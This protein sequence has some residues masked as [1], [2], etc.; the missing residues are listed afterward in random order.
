MIAQVQ[1]TTIP[2]NWLSG[3][4]TVATVNIGSACIRVGANA[5][6]N[7][8]ALTT[9]NCLATTAPVLG[10]SAFQTVNATLITV[11]TGALNYGS[12]WGG[13]NVTYGGL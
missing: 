9:I 1:D 11:P 7:C 13:L 8:Y 12:T 4:T 3:N 6:K 5:F 10:A 2:D